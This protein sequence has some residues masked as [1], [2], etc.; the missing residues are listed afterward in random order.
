MK[1]KSFFFELLF[2]PYV[3]FFFITQS[4]IFESVFD[5]I[6][7]RDNDLDYLTHG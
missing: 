5:E 7:K 3:S 6:R 2:Y 4:R 1:K